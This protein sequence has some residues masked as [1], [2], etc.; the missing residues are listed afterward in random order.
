MKKPITQ[1]YSAS[2]FAL[3]QKVGAMTHKEAMLN[4]GL[5]RAKVSWLRQIAK[6]RN[7]QGMTPEHVYEASL[8]DRCSYWL[9]VAKADRLS[10][11]QLRA[12]I[13]GSRPQP[14]TKDLQVP[15]YLRNLML[16]E[17]ELSRTKNLNKPAVIDA[18]NRINALLN[19]L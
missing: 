17:V 12:R 9:K 16:V 1:D 19:K 15:T 7:T 18:L 13:R 11:V 5:T 8:T 14:K 10:P 3:A 6:V 4:T 2:T